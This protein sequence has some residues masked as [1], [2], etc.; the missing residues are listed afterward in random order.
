[1]E[2]VQGTSH[3]AMRLTRCREGIVERFASIK[4]T[5][6]SHGFSVKMHSGNVTAKPMRAIK[7]DMINLV[8]S[9][10]PVRSDILYI[11]YICIYGI[12]YTRA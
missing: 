3:H 5:D 7:I 2:L 6:I 12:L 9:L 1:M 11:L 10:T 8:T 4:V